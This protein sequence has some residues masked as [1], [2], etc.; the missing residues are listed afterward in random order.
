MKVEECCGPRGGNW[1]KINSAMKLWSWE[2]WKA[3]RANERT[4]SELII[5][6]GQS[7]KPLT[8]QQ[9][10]GRHTRQ[11][12]RHDMVATVAKHAVVDRGRVSF[13]PFYERRAQSFQL[14]FATTAG[15]ETQPAARVNSNDCE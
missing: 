5:A 15:R 14:S 7:S 1:K 13:R 10:E 2:A 3:G 9:D 6:S 8:Q 11:A 12:S 4:A